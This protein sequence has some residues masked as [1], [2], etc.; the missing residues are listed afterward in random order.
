MTARVLG[1]ALALLLGACASTLQH[2]QRPGLGFAGPRLEPHAFVS[3]D[4][5]SLGL[6]EWDAEGGAPWAVIIGLHGMNDYANAFH[7][8]A[9]YWASV[10]LTTIAYDQRFAVGVAS[11]HAILVTVGLD[12]RGVDAVHRGA[13]DQPQ[14]QPV[15][16]GHWRC[17]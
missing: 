3:Y 17:R 16:P 15:R 7:L 10:G 8:A 9:R 1:V 5:A 6:S 12:Q 14:S 11:I 4:G 2:P 13:A